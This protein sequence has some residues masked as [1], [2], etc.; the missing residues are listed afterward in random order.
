MTK[1]EIISTGISI[2]ALALTILIPISQWIWRNWIVT[3]K[4][5]YYPTGQATLFFNQSGAYMRINGIIESERKAS[6]IKIIKITVTRKKDER[7]LNL[8]W[9]YIISPISQ[10]MLGNYLQTLEMAHPFR[11]EAD[12]IACA[13]VEYSDSSDSTGI[14]IR[15]I[16]TNI[17]NE[18]HEI[19]QGQNYDQALRKFLKSPSYMSAK[20][21]IINEF[22]WEAG[23]YTVEIV[24]EYGKQSVGIFTYD[25]SVSEQNYCNMQNNID[26]ILIAQ[27]KSYYQ[28]KPNF[29]SPIIEFSEKINK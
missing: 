26:E 5:K 25:F 6:T 23:Q 18:I 1:Y 9:S 28:I 24:V 15:N 2:I 14:K 16:C 12:S 20:S 21:Q 3:A 11:V 17:E 8:T 10:N 27:L 29:Y 7:K 22:F 19:V 4:V 13:F